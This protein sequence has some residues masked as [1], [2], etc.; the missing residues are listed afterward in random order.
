MAIAVSGASS[1]LLVDNRGYRTCRCHPDGSR[2]DGGRRRTLCL[3]ACR[4]YPG[5]SGLR[6]LPVE[7]MLR[8]AAWIPR[9]WRQGYDA[10]NIYIFT[11]CRRYERATFTSSMGMERNQSIQSKY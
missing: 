3:T 10:T 6:R 8:I 2:H 4:A 7:Q 1:D 11:P 5:A 9:L